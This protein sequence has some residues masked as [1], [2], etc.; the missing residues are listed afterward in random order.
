MFTKL[1]KKKEAICFFSCSRALSLSLRSGIWCTGLHWKTSVVDV[2]CRCEWSDERSYDIVRHSLF[3]CFAQST[4]RRTNCIRRQ[5]NGS[6][7]MIAPATTQLKW[8]ANTK[9]TGGLDCR[10]NKTHL[11]MR[12][13]IRK[14]KMHLCA[15]RENGMLLACI[16][17]YIQT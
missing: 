9:A 11:Q 16:R 15:E 5:L 8:L 14:K 7:K 17:A 10:G 12:S 3:F 13:R 2:R 1:K 4:Y 6:R